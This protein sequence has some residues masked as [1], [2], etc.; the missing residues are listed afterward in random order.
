LQNLVVIQ[1]KRNE[2]NY[3]D[4]REKFDPSRAAFQGH[5][6]LSEPTGFDRLP[7]ARSWPTAIADPARQPTWRSSV[8]LRVIHVHIP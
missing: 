6:R 5:S 2:R 8:F 4:T 3:G 7:N 1:A